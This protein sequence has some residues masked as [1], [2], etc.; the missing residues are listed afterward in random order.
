LL[1][2]LCCA[3]IS[4]A[5]SGVSSAIKPFAT[6]AVRT[7]KRGPKRISV[8]GVV[9]ATFA[10][11]ICAVSSVAAHRFGNAAA[12]VFAYNRYNAGSAARIAS[13]IARRPATVWC[14]KIKHN[15][16]LSCFISCFKKP[17]VPIYCL[18]NLF[19]QFDSAIASKF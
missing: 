16:H 10:E 8:A 5:N 14:A 9:V 7:G 6:Q 15:Y 4:A 2:F 19:Q 11:L 17:F 3:K 1:N 13:G 12:R 18:Y